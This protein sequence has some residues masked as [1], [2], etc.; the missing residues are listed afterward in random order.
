MNPFVAIV[1][2]LAVYGAVVWIVLGILAFCAEGAE[3]WDQTITDHYQD[4]DQ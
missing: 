2:L 3:R 4:K 1:L